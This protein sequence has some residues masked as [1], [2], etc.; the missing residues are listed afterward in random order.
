[1]LEQ[2]VVLGGDGDEVS[3]IEVVLLGMQVEAR[4]MLFFSEVS[5]PPRAA[6]LVGRSAGLVS[7]LSTLRLPLAYLLLL[8]LGGLGG[9]GGILAGGEGE[10]GICRVRLR[11]RLLLFRSCI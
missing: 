9:L 1:M 5:R 7:F 2:R 3:P 4:F 11:V 6:C 10:C 8:R